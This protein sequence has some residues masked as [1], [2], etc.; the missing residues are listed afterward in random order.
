MIG[1]KMGEKKAVYVFRID[2]SLRKA[3]Y[4]TPAAIKQEPLAGHF[5]K[6]G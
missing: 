1:V 3:N 4:D 6:N 2:S 5:D